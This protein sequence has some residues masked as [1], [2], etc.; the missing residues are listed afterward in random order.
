MQRDLILAWQIERMRLMTQRD[1]RL[2]DLRRLLQT[3]GPDAPT[4]AQM[5]SQMA[6]LSQRLGVPLRTR[7]RRS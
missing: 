4:A 3:L 1:K 5:R 2:P 7:G 6:M